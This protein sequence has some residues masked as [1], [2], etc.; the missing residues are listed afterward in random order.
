M[1]A[2][3]HEL[4]DENW[5]LEVYGELEALKQQLSSLN[6]LEGRLDASESIMDATEQQGRV[7]RVCL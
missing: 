6:G 2:Q 4:Q 1:H 3:L 7:M 5:K